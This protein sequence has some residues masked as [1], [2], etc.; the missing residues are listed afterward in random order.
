[1]LTYVLA[2]KESSNRKGCALISSCQ[3]EDGQLSGK[4]PQIFLQ[5]RVKISGASKCLRTNKVWKGHG[6][7]FQLVTNLGES[8]TSSTYFSSRDR[9]CLCQDPDARSP[10][11]VCKPA[12]RI[13]FQFWGYHCSIR[14]LVSP[15]VLDSPK[16]LESILSQWPPLPPWRHKTCRPKWVGRVN[17][18]KADLLC[19]GCWWEIKLRTER[20]QS[21]MHVPYRLGDVLEPSYQYSWL[22]IGCYPEPAATTMDRK[23]I[24]WMSCSGSWQ[25]NLHHPN[26]SIRIEDRWSSDSQVRC[27]PVQGSCG[28]LFSVWPRLNVPKSPHR[29]TTKTQ[30]AYNRTWVNILQL[31]FGLVCG[32]CKFGSLLLSFLITWSSQM[33]T[34]RNKAIWVHPVALKQRNHM[35]MQKGKH[36]FI[37]VFKINAWWSNPQFVSVFQAQDGFQRF[38][39]KLLAPICFIRIHPQ[40]LK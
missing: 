2:W 1:M 30:L 11:L 17:G 31:L 16:L 7:K 29:R 12:L 37:F 25:N 18:E 32:Q 14:S 21:R 8:H 20:I 4:L 24:H 36:N 10:Q 39:G 9:R 26:K 34:S 19:W 3:G 38:I 27:P 15:T 5:R 22:Q 6:N 35:T 28:K 33:V 40:K 13:D 23:S